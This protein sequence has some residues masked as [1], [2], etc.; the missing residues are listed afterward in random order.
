M[1]HFIK[2]HKII[3]VIWF[4]F[5]HV[6]IDAEWNRTFLSHRQNCSKGKNGF[7]GNYGVRGQ[8]SLLFVLRNNNA[9]EMYLSTDFDVSMH[10][11]IN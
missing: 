9:I 11:H 6:R 10:V 5:T 7:T 2:Y 1:L 8:I 4:V 3:S